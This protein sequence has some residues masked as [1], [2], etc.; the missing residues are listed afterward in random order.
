[1]Y[2]VSTLFFSCIDSL[3]ASSSFAKIIPPRNILPPYQSEWFLQHVSVG[4][5]LP[6]AQEDFF[7]SISCCCT[8]RLLPIAFSG[9]NRDMRMSLLTTLSPLD[10][11]ISSHAQMTHGLSVYENS[12]K[13]GFESRGQHPTTCL[14]QKKKSKK[15]GF[16]K[17]SDT[18]C[19]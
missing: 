10:T 12:T 8:A 2:I 19:L 18:S 1:M 6:Q 7:E 17:S 11:F 9:V 5:G 13:A 14:Y 3:F 16:E 4:I 15:P